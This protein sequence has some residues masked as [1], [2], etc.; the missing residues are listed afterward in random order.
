MLQNPSPFTV[1][2]TSDSFVCMVVDPGNEQD[3][4][5]TGV[6]IVG[7][8]PNG[9]AARGGLRDGDV[10]VKVVQQAV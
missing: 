3:V 1:G 6:Q 9:P 10:I 5:V 4:W 7:V 2:G 8:V